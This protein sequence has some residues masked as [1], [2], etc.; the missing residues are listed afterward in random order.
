MAG[1][2]RARTWDWT[3]TKPGDLASACR[4]DRDIQPGSVRMAVSAT[5]LK[6]D[7]AVARPSTGFKFFVNLFRA[8]ERRLP[9]PEHLA[10]SGGNW[11]DARLMA[12]TIGTRMP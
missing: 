10:G 9:D 11:T 2:D 12:L 1:T 7:T 6:F 4:Q 8:L 5:V 3:G